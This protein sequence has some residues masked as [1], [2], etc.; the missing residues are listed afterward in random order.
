MARVLTVSLDGTRQP[1]VREI[2]WSIHRGP[3]HLSLA[4]ALV[5]NATPH[6]VIVAKGLLSGRH[7]VGS[8][9]A[10]ITAPSPQGPGLAEAQVE[11]PL[12]HGLS[13]LGVD[14]MVITGQAPTPLGVACEG[15][16]GGITVSVTDAGDLSAHSVSA[17]HSVLETSPSDVILTTGPLGMA[18]NPAASVV[19]NRGFPTTQGGLGAVF[20]HLGLDHLVLR[21]S[22]E[23]PSRTE[24]E[25][26]ITGAYEAAIPGN[27]L[28]ASE[29]NYPGFAMW[30]GDDL[31]GYAASPGFSGTLTA[32]ARDFDSSA[33]MAFARDDGSSA[34]P[35][36]P[37]WCL[38]S[39]TVGDG[40]PVDSGRAHQLGISGAA[41]MLDVT[42]PA[43]LVAFNATCHD[44]GIEHLSAIDAL[45]GQT[46]TRDTLSDQIVTA[47]SDHPLGPEPRLRVKGMVIPPFDPRGNQGLGVGYALNPTG[48]RYDVLEHDIDF[49]AGQHWMGRENLEGDFGIAPDGIPMATLDT[50]RH[51][52]LVK[53]WVAWSAM[54]ALGLCEY[55]APPTREL[56]IESMCEVVAEVTGEPFTREDYD[57][58]GKY[59]LAI[60]RD[61]N[62]MLGVTSKHD[63]LPD[64]FFDS[65][66]VDGDLAGAVISR[67]EFDVAAEY[68]R[69]RLGWA[70]G[71]GLADGNRARAIADTSQTVWNLVKGTQS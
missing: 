37:Q 71:G 12:A 38:K 60:L 20:G 41:L 49:I 9:T 67:E 18:G 30:M 31:V 29:R 39:F 52:S 32:G 47:V 48:P 69:S 25:A 65:P 28:T 42:D 54:D 13:R 10:T 8:A 16:G 26:K 11:G 15:H 56:T 68:V 6:W 44:L 53:L 21:G 14:A 22:G 40:E 55:A 63:T 5:A 58:L 34:C 57:K 51:E 2:P 7:L 1:G 64:H 50:S 36:C 61:I 43:T 3:I 24:V 45:R 27:P 70:H 62:N 35:G 17:K 46:M 4:H 66:V 19:V 33:M 23:A 59:R